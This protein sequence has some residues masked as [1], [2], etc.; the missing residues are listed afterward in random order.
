M[1]KRIGCAEVW[2]GIE[3]ADQDL[4]TGAIS[5]SL[6]SQSAEGGKGGDIYFL[7]VC[8]GDSLTRV[9]VADVMGHGEQVSKIS[10]W[11]FTSLK[12][13][14]NN[15]SGEEI[16]GNLNNTVETKGF[17]AMTTAA[18]AGIIRQQGRLFFTYAGHP[19]IMVYRER[20][21]AWTA[22]R[23]AQEKTGANMPLGVVSNACYDQETIE[24]DPGDKL[25]I[26]TDGIL[27]A[28]DPHG[29]FFGQERLLDVLSNHGRE[30][31]AKLKTAVRQALENH[32]NGA[33]TH[34]DVT[35]M[36]IQVH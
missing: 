23:L 25:F 4:E 9:A 17:Q 21:R 28:P 20:Q 3:N 26:Y 16:L 35:I 29:D 14:L 11:V 18:L 19:P 31:P 30:R 36:A 1:T 10:D 12:H 2:G 15:P 24:L 34:D 6:F 27:E 33:I 13:H 7:S 22:A 32:C 5:A 8:G